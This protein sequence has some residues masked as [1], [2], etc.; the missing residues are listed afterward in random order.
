MPD[1]DLQCASTA[2]VPD[3]DDFHHW[4]AAALAGRRDDW[5]L[6]IRLVDED[7]SRLLNRDYRGH[8]R[9]TN[10]LSFPAELPADVAL[11]LLGDLVICA[12][13]VIREAAGQGK[14][15]RAH[16]AHLTIHG[17][18]HL[19]GFD[20]MTSVEAECMEGEERAIMARL[21]WPDPYA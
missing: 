10:V 9:P 14:T 2:P 8:D 3:A 15:E 7:E 17:V 12:P 4:V 11:P 19:L 6:A 1:L 5:E 21:G 20:H 18:L 16:W 13:V